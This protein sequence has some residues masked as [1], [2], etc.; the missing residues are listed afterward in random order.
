MGHVGGDAAPSSFFF[1][2]G[3][4]G[5]AVVVTLMMVLVVG[6]WGGGLNDVAS[7]GV[8]VVSLFRCGGGEAGD[9]DSTTRRRGALEQFNE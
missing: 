7:F 3:T 5:Y 9:G 6:G 1:F 8:G 2:L 4:R